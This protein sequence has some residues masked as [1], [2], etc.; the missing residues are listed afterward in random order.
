M[1]P[2]RRAARRPLLVAD[3]PSLLFR[4]YYALP[5]SIK[6]AG[7]LP[8]N[9]LLG[10]LNLM[11]REIGAHDPR[12]VVMA[13]GQ[14]A[15]D[16]RVELF[17][18]YHADRRDLEVDEDIDRQ[19]EDAPE[20]YAAFGWEPVGFPG[21]EADDVLNSYALAE[22]ERGGRVL[23]VTGDRDMFQCVNDDCA[24]LYLTTGT[25]GAVTVDEAEVRRRYGVPP[26]LVP[27]LIALRGDPSDGIPGARGIGEKTAAD[28]LRRHGSLEGAIAG[29]AGE[30]PRVRAALHEQADELRAFREV[31][32]LREVP[33]EAPP[34][35]PTDREAGAA[36]ARELGM[37]RLAERLERERGG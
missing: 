29:W 10:S 5:R 3:A 23:L 27:D 6:G 15:A 22:Q 12:A 20:L 33:V 1:P 37:N 11:L 26:A 7:G 8:V 31:A 35:R 36:A 30:S 19:F 18:A 25:K 9:A 2:R 17:P 28:L 13:F 21:L 32:T 14:D 24:V 34:D 16:Y 4:A